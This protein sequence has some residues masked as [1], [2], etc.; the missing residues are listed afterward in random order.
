MVHMNFNKRAV[1]VICCIS[2]FLVLPSLLSAS[3][4]ELEATEV[5][6][7]SLEELL[8]IEVDIA[9]RHSEK[10]FET[11][12]AVYVIT[13][14]D[15][16]R[17]GISRIPELLRLVPGF[18]V[19]QI[20]G[21]TWSIGSRGFKDS[22]GDKLLVLM[23]GR[24]IYS[25]LFGGVYW[26]VQDYVLEDIERIEVIRGPGATMW[27]ANAV[28]GVVNIITKHSNDTEGGLAV[29]GAGTNQDYLAVG[30]YG[31]WINDKCS[32]R[33]YGKNNKRNKNVYE[34]GQDAS[35]STDIP[36]LGFRLDWA[37]DGQ[38]SFN[39]QGDYY[40]GTRDLNK[41][42]EEED[43]SGTNIM[44]KWDHSIS[45]LSAL[46]LQLYYDRTERHSLVIGQDRDTYDIDFKHNFAVQ[47]NELVWGVAYH[48][49]SDQI[50]NDRIT[51]L[52]PDS[53]SDKLFSAFLQDKIGVT[54]N[55]WLTVGCKIEENDYTG[56]EYQ[57]SVKMM[58]VANQCHSSW[59][60][61]SRAVKTPDRIDHDFDI[62]MAMVGPFA[63]RAEGNDQMYA[64]T[65]IAYEVGY[66]FKPESP[67][68]IDV[69]AFYNDYDDVSGKNSTTDFVNREIIISF[70]NTRV[71][72]S[73]GFESLLNWQ[74]NPTWKLSASWSYLYMDVTVADEDL[75]TDSEI[76]DMNPQN[77]A[78]IRSYWNINSYIDFDVLAFY[79]DEVYD[80][81]V[82][83]FVR[84]DLR[85]GLHPHE[86]VE[87]SLGVQNALD[88]A[89]SE[90]VT[91]GRN[92][93]SEIERNF[94]GK[95]TVQF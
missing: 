33:L 78:Q 76:E 5:F 75:D 82:E 22:H 68:S 50:D 73:Y 20:D 9:S 19:S 49:T 14:E 54:D 64:E 30:R 11:P 65:M 25:P 12:S 87:I 3:E 51:T 27:G 36:R 35:D 69:T 29:A 10:I 23:D 93:I 95:V 21:N 79:V 57:P 63:L 38:N 62:L 55:L 42:Q 18:T 24:S 2:Y 44:V 46:T 84:L 1:Q 48:Y 89:H 47:R 71:A 56:F 80:G 52:M 4:S 77:Q 40:D 45:S 31:D 32:Y 72:E 34:N 39:V 53:R 91:T 6:S 66:R 37:K 16:R 7:M 81:D 43:V 90:E 61:I 28:N 94:W 8:D 83:S 41:W 26:D 60:S 17:S 59:A 70:D 92:T 58:W 67:F 13:S 85:V 86:K 74:V 15:I 88:A